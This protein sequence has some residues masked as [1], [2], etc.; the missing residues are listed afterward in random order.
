M[1]SKLKFEFFFTGPMD[2]LDQIQKGL[3][4][5]QGE[6]NCFLNGGLQLLSH[7]QEFRK[8]F[9]KAIHTCKT[10]SCLFCQMKVSQ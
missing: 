3:T 8:S 7:N 1:K 9:E 4:N 10:N 5:L 6:N 2:S